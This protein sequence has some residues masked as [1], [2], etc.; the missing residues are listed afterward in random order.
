ME[1]LDLGI[2]DGVITALGMAVF[3]STDADLDASDYHVLPGLVDPHVHFNEPG[4]TEWEGFE[5]GTRALAAGGVTTY[6]DMPLH[7]LPPVVDR[8][9]VSWPSGISGRRVRWSISAS[10]VA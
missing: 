1:K 5:S 8:G 9:V 2:K 3:G 7:S 6:L 4:R 10:G